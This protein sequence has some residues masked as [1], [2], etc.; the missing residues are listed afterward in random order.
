M[1][2]AFKYGVVEAGGTCISTCRDEMELKIDNLRD[3][4]II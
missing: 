3:Q 4:Y 2:V 1:A